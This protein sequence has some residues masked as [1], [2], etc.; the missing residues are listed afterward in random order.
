MPKDFKD[1]YQQKIYEIDL[2]L[3]TTARQQVPLLR[4]Q[5]TLR[6]SDTLRRMLDRY[7]KRITDLQEKYPIL[8]NDPPI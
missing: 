8:K 1:S 6:E 5:L 3:Y 2:K 7:E 4:E